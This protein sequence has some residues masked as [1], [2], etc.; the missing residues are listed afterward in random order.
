MNEGVGRLR[1]PHVDLCVETGE[2][3][4]ALVR[5]NLNKTKN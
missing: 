3:H 5:Y 1:M 2:S 4:D